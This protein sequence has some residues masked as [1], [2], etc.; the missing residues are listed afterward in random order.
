MKKDKLRRIQNR[1]WYRKKIGNWGLGINLFSALQSLLCVSLYVLFSLYPGRLSAH[2]GGAPVLTD[3]PAG[4]YRL[5][6]WM[7]PEPLQAGDV[8]LS[9]VV[10]LAPEDAAQSSALDTPITDAQVIARFEPVSQPGQVITTPLPSQTG[11]GGFYYEA[12]V[13]LPQ[14]DLWRMTVEVS[15]AA[16][17]G[18][19]TFE[20]QVV[21][22][23]SVDW[24]VVSSAGLVLIVLI[25][26]MGAWN[27]L[28]TKG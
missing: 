12:D 5:F 22:R 21:P 16:G 9:V 28:Q 25:G 26:L 15:G 19:A 20:R 24:R 17:V 27:R 18:S 13:V 11:L 14:A 3:Q 10:M 4:P 8:H 1:L 23:R 2:T 6:A 7:Q